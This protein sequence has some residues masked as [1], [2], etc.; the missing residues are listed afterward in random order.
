M[1]KIIAPAFASLLAA[2]AAGLA[3]AP[4]D[5]TAQQGTPLFLVPGGGPGQEYVLIPTPRTPQPGQ[6]MAMG[7]QQGMAGG[8]QGLH[9]TDPG[10]TGPGWGAPGY[11]WQG[12]NAFERAE[13]RSLTELVAQEAYRRGYEQGQ[14]DAQRRYQAGAMGPQGQLGPAD[15]DRFG[16]E[17]FERGLQLG[18]FEEQMRRTGEE[19]RAMQQVRGSLQDARRALQQ[20]NEQ[21]ARQALDEAEQTLRARGGQQEELRQ[22]LDEA[23]QALQQGDTQGAQEALRRA[24]QAAGGQEQA[25]APPQP[26]QQGTQQQGQPGQQQQQQQ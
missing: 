11:W 7:Q 3:L 18:R 1:R 21:Q 17:V 4:S 13:P 19:E 6:G 24:R 25:Q 14:L 26:G 12:P 5:A 15:L 2:G 20:G 22:A 16:R 23:D 8:Q 10:V 9:Y